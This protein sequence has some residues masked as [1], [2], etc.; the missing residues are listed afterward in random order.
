VG[1]GR[2]QVTPG[3][4]YR[5]SVKAKRIG[6][7]SVNVRAAVRWFDSSGT[8]ISTDTAFTTATT[9]GDVVYEG[10]LTAPAGAAKAA[11]RLFG[12]SF[13]GSPTLETWEPR[14]DRRT[15]NTRL[16]D[17][18]VDSRTI[19]ATNPLDTKH[20]VTGPLVQSHSGGTT[21]AK[22]TTSGIFYYIGGATKFSATSSGVFVTGTLTTGSGAI[23]GGAGLADI[24]FPSGSGYTIGES[25]GFLEYKAGGSGHKFTGAV[26][27]GSA[28][29][30]SGSTTLNGTAFLNAGSASVNGSGTTLSFYGGTLRTFSAVNTW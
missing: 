16:T 30:V 24:Q 27:V 11:I 25:G 29:T 17:D 21:G 2:R 7:T 13:V 12:N 4:E 10:N 28:L 9:T 22:L 15:V 6:G 14:L 26:L 23:F 1:R 3:E 5:V 19:I 20:T 8:A 18:A